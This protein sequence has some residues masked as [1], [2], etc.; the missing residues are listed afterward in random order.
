MTIIGL[1]L[2][3][4]DIAGD[5][6]AG[7]LLDRIAFWFA[8]NQEGQSKLRVKHKG[9]TWLAKGRTDWYAECR[10]SPRQVDR[11]LALLREAKLIETDLIPFNGKATT[12]I[13]LNSDVL[14]QRLA[15]LAEPSPN[16]ESPSPN[17]ESEAKDDS[18]NGESPSPTRESPS[19][20]G[21][22]PSPARDGD[23][24]DGESNN[25]GY[26]GDD[27]GIQ[28]GGRQGGRQGDPPAP[29]PAPPPPPPR[30]NSFTLYEQNVGP[31]TPLIADH[32]RDFEA[33]YGEEWLK[34]AIEVAAERNKRSIKYIEATLKGCRAEGKPPKAP[35]ASSSNGNGHK[36]GRAGVPGT[37]APGME[38]QHRT[39]IRDMTP[40]FREEVLNS[41]RQQRKAQQHD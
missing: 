13:W 38:K 20:G 28:Q 8:P 14:K 15:A 10:L 9:K 17:G 18:P 36:P 7:L 19:P 32:L 1:N 12:H 35:K 3:Y 25:R 26:T 41:I 37:I 21:E 34:Q 31:L 30:P 33:D 27:Q 40:E 24:P 11:A 2:D 39:D 22:S 4:I 23:S 16:G 5:V 6:N 29:A